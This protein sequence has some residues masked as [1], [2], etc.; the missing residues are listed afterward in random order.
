LPATDEAVA[1]WPAGLID[2]MAALAAGLLSGLWI[3]LI[4]GRETDHWSTP[5]LIALGCAVGVVL[6]WQPTPLWTGII[7]IFALLLAR[8]LPNPAPH[9]E[10]APG[11]ESPAVG[12]AAPLVQPQTPMPPEEILPVPP[13]QEIDPP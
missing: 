13:A 1:N 2:G 6:G 12:D 8:L 4:R 9:D 5:A 3:R 10:P 11:A 7:W